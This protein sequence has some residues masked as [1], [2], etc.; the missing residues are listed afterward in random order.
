MDVVAWAKSQIN[1][2]EGRFAIHLLTVYFILLV[3]S[4]IK[5]NSIRPHFGS[6]TEPVLIGVLICEAALL[7]IAVGT[8]GHYGLSIAPP[9]FAQAP[10]L[11]LITFL[12]VSLLALG[13]IFSQSD[14]DGRKVIRFLGYMGLW[15]GGI[16]FYFLSV[17]DPVACDEY[18]KNRAFADLMLQEMNISR[19]DPAASA[20][21]GLIK[22]SKPGYEAYEWVC[23]Y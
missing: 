11:N 4:T 15:V 18:D 17:L 1:S 3:Y 22:S 19:G 7:P 21:E 6:S 9:D 16:F 2:P 23:S 12:G 10:G 14:S 5:V 13:T 8:L 20:I